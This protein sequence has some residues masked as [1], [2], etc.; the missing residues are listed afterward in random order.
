[1]LY[2]FASAANNNGSA[3]GGLTVTSDWFQTALGI[4]ML[5]GRFLP[6]IFV[7]ALAGLLASS[8]PRPSSSAT[9]PTHGLLYGGLLTG[10]VLLVAGLTFFPAMALGP[11]AEAL[12]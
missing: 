9:L 8:K 7:L 5:L 6:I 10:T 3:F 11:I 12:S 2:A 1:V 4:A